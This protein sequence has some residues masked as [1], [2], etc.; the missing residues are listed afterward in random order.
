MATFASFIL[1]QK[2]DSQL[3]DTWASDISFE[4]VDD[5]ISSFQ[6][7]PFVKQALQNNI[8]LRTYSIQIQAELATH[9]E[10]LAHQHLKQV[11]ETLELNN[12]LDE[13]D[14]VLGDIDGLLGGYKRDLQKM[15]HEIENIQKDSK[16][17]GIKLENRKNAVKYSNELLDG[18]VV[19]PDIIRK[20]C[21]GEINEFFIHHLHELNVKMAYVVANEDKQVKALK[22]VGPELER[23]RIKAADKI[24]EFL[25]KK[26][27]SL[28][29]PNTNI[30]LIQQNALLKYKELFWFLMERFT[31]VGLEIHAN[32]IVIVSTY[33]STA[34]D[35]YVKVMNK[36]QTS[37]ADKNDV[38]G[39]DDGSKRGL[40]GIRT[41][42]DTTNL[43]TMGDRINLLIGND[44]GIIVPH[45]AEEKNQKFTFEQIFKSVSR[46][47][48]DNASSEYIFTNEF[49]QEK[50]IKTS[51]ESM[52]FFNEVFDPT[53]KIIQTF[54][55]QYIDQTHDA[56]SIL[57]CIRLNTLNIRLLQLRRIPCLENFL[58][59]VNIMLWPRFQTIMGLHID[60]LKKAEP[61]KL[62]S[63]REPQP[64]YIIRRYAEFSASVLTLNEGYDDALSRLRTELESL[65]YR[66]AAEFPDKKVSLAFWINN[67]DLIQTIMNEHTSPSL[68][69]EKLYFED[70][71]KQKL[72]EFV[73]WQLSPYLKS[74]MDYIVKVESKQSA[75]NKDESYPTQSQ[76]FERQAQIPGTRIF[77]YEYDIDKP[78]KRKFIVSKTR[79]FWDT[80]I[81]MENKHF[82][83]LIREDD[84]CNLYFDLEYEYEYNMIKNDAEEPLFSTSKI[85]TYGDSLQ[86][87]GRESL[88][89]ANQSNERLEISINDF[90]KV[91][92]QELHLLGIENFKIIDLDSSNNKKY[93]HHLIVRFQHSKFKNNQHCGIFVNKFYK[94][95][96][97]NNLF[98]IKTKEE[99]KVFIDH[100]VYT[101][102]RNFRLYLS[103]KIGKDTILDIK[104]ATPR[105]EIFLDTLVVDDRGSTELID[106]GDSI[107]PSLCIGAETRKSSNIC[108]IVGNSNYPEI[109]YSILSYIHR[110]S[111]NTAS[112]KSFFILEE[113]I[114]YVISGSRYCHRLQRDHKS[115]SVYYIADLKL[116]NFHQRCFDPDCRNYRSPSVDF[117]LDDYFDISDQQIVQAVEPDNKILQKPVERWKFIRETL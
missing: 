105:F 16:E 28:K 49:F 90:I 13:M 26:I 58:N 6:Q 104:N 15:N 42:K 67:I 86:S 24:R 2:V 77:S 51:S 32:Y 34:F 17:L 52:S 94:K 79:D 36:L 21:E 78:G 117:E 66:L 100:G 56:I 64:H 61:R 54:F 22:N 53:L 93:S 50:S 27:E 47:V 71:M 1:L 68:D 109:E 14:K 75:T 43:Y 108:T 70:L 62:L 45:L 7:D 8:P 55:K 20:I 60:S 96:I 57:V 111:R 73:E 4:E 101:K 102:N 87:D 37:I 114:M 80:Y 110:F 91:L 113:K 11:H 40:F 19:G 33:F 3:E 65:M 99:D 23:L 39:S 18:I 97:D 88:K 76:A 84:P 5:R 30:A 115:N 12:I 63:V 44:T 98:I 48:L 82:Y 10:S 89:L 38:I 46:L 31:P 95:L 74:M 41:V 106:Y 112:I 9:Q 25:L 83:E 107:K 29:A 116:M 81:Q 35:K 59:L 85:A 72:D 69:Q 92:K 103:S